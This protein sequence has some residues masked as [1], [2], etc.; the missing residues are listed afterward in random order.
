MIRVIWSSGPVNRHNSH[1][2]R[3][4]VNLISSLFCYQSNS[5]PITAILLFFFHFIEFHFSV[6]FIWV[7]VAVDSMR[8]GFLFPDIHSHVS[9][10]AEIY[11]AKIIERPSTWNRQV[12]LYQEKLWIHFAETTRLCVF[13][14]GTPD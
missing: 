1:T 3:K 11:T 13:I 10:W 9:L 6:L 2:I 4:S 14:Y 7:V 8:C 12:N 5:Y